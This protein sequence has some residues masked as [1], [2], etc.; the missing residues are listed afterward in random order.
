MQKQHPLLKD[1][2]KQITIYNF[3][4]LDDGTAV[5]TKPVAIKDA[6]EIGARFHC[7]ILAPNDAPLAA[8][9]QVIGFF[10]TL[11]PQHAFEFSSTVTE[12]ISPGHIVVCFVTT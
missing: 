8:V 1:I 7:E 4:L 2:N 12:A 9:T 10:E 3:R 5:P 6:A 11:Y